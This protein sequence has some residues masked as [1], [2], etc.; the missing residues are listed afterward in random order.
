MRR[1]ASSAPGIV[2]NLF[3]VF[4]FEEGAGDRDADVP[5]VCDLACADH[6]RERGAVQRRIVV[7]QDSECEQR[8]VRHY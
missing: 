4:L 6:A 3:Y 5:S 1:S 2:A 7:P 8:T